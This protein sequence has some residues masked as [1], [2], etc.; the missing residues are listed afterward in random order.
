MAESFVDDS[1]HTQSCIAW[2]LVQYGRDCSDI[3]TAPEMCLECMH[4]N[5]SCRIP[6][7]GDDNR[8]LLWQLANQPIADRRPD[9][10]APLNCMLQAGAEK[11]I[12]SVNQMEATDSESRETRR[13]KTDPA[14]EAESCAIEHSF[15]VAIIAALKRAQVR[16]AEDMKEVVLKIYVCIVR[17]FSTARLAVCSFQSTASLQML[18]IKQKSMLCLFSCLLLA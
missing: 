12:V 5:K 15:A 8:D 7:S 18:I 11:E 9:P 17:R 13:T 2:I 6:L 14:C 10:G 4:H 1:S 16:R 3:V